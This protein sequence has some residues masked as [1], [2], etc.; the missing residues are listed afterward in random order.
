MTS[1]NSSSSLSSST[2]S[3]RSHNEPPQPP[4]AKNHGLYAQA[5]PVPMPPPFACKI[6][7]FC[8]I[9]KLPKLPTMMNSNYR[10]HAM[11]MQQNEKQCVGHNI[12]G[13]MNHDQF[14]S[15]SNTK[16]SHSLT[17]FGQFSNHAQVNHNNYNNN[18]TSNDNATQHNHANIMNHNNPF[19]CTSVPP[20][21]RLSFGACNNGNIHST[22][23]GNKPT[24][25]CLDSKQFKFGDNDVPQCAPPTFGHR[26]Q[27]QVNEHGN[28]NHNLSQ[29][30][31][32]PFLFPITTSFNTNNDDDHGM[33]TTL[34]DSSASIPNHH[35]N[36]LSS[37]TSANTQH[38]KL[39]A[40]GA[41]P[42]LATQ[43]TS[44]S[45]AT[46]TLSSSANSSALP[47]TMSNPSV[48]PIALMTAESEQSQSETADSKADE[49]E[50]RYACTHCSK[51]FKHKSNLRIHQIIHTK[52]ALKCNYCDKRFARKGNL[53]QHLRVHTDERPY[54]CVF[55]PK[56][57]KQP[58]SLKDHLRIHTGE[59][60]FECKFCGKSFNVKH[61]MVIH[62]RLHTGE[63]PF[64]CVICAKKFASKSSLNGHTKKFH[65]A[66]WE[67]QHSK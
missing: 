2:I 1:S 19:Q 53:K 60:P 64:D 7:D 11:S 49:N 67:Q 30:V 27:P 12:N 55:C 52:A 50:A 14:S 33:K 9:P 8:N 4:S 58:H 6:S 17:G 37:S 34:G 65:A 39:S 57:F 48:P 40:F 15:G 35:M 63:R 66:S 23:N 21:P 61:N 36:H 43:Q 16:Y 59:K 18:K 51:A 45:A 38:C 47:A 22:A 32:D 10:Q 31:H 26:N 28:N 20:V 56:K 42:M 44:V 54:S 24:S 46:S 5:P 62:S 41:P 13:N 3:S 29:Q 25:I